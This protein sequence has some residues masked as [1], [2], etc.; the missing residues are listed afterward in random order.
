MTRDSEFWLQ[1][2]K[3]TIDA[4]SLR[5]GGTALDIGCAG[6]VATR[7]MAAAAGAAVGVDANEAILEEAR[8][9]TGPEYEARFERATAD[10]LPFRD[11]AFTGVRI[12]RVLQHVDDLGAASE[13]IWRVAEPGAGIVAIEPDWDTLIFDAGPLAATRAVTRAWADSVRNPVA[14]RQIARR[15]R[16]LG[17]T[18]VRA[19]PRTAA[20]TQLAYAE[21]Q[22][23]LTPLAEAALRP[24]AAR[25]W[26]GTL[27]QRD[28]DGT[29]LSA[30]TYF[31]V[32]GRKP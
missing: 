29:F 19:E 3:A 5:H 25:A 15:L 31:L 21:E 23:G 13:E 2:T 1:A 30:V 32:S 16:K 20:I 14:G 4:L 12:D 28:A 6:G 22:Y 8:R 11:G 18:D 9:L 7:H 10:N 17:A 26:L 27:G 24:A